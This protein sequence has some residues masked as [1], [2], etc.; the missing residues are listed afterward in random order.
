MNLCRVVSKDGG[1]HVVDPEWVTVNTY[2]NDDPG[3]DKAYAHALALN[4]NLIMKRLLS[5]KILKQIAKEAKP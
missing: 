4:E 5:K 3:I 2:P 1:L